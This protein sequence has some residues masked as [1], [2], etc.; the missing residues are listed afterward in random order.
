VPTSRNTKAVD[1]LVHIPRN[2]KSVGVQ[3]K[4]M[5]QK[6]IEEPLKDI[7][8]VHNAIPEYPLGTI[9]GLTMCMAALAVFKSRHKGIQ[10]RKLI[11][12]LPFLLASS[13]PWD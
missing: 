4:T 9:L 13:R 5:R 2:N 10:L 3:V 8:A 1:L 7:Y 6:L 11:S 12:F